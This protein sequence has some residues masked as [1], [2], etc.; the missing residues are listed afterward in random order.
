[1]FQFQ[2]GAIIRVITVRHVR[3]GRKFQFQHGAIIRKI[4]TLCKPRQMPV[5]IPAWCDYKADY[6]INFDDIRRF[7]FQ[8]GAIIRSVLD[9]AQMTTAMFQ[10]QHGAIIRAIV[11]PPYA[12][13]ARFQFQHGAIISLNEITGGLSGIEFQFQHGAIIRPALSLQALSQARFN[14]SM[15]RL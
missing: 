5:S 9:S 7:Q 8:H 1:M 13:G 6:F 14:S 2:H 12:V 15:V 10:F 11:D 3:A 4:R